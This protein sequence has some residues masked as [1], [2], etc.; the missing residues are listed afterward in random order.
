M[1]NSKFLS[2]KDNKVTDIEPCTARTQQ[3]YI[4][5]RPCTKLGWVNKKT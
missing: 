4:H 1:I 2:T 5:I 3:G